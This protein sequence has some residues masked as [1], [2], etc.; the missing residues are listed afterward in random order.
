M[1]LCWR[2]ADD[3]ARAHVQALQR[4]SRTQ[5]ARKVP[6]SRPHAAGRAP[7]H[8]FFH[9]RGTLGGHGPSGAVASHL[10]PGSVPILMHLNLQEKKF[11]NKNKA[12]ATT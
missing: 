1:G 11:R 3:D 7:E 6:T 9:A 4:D 12:K 10:P 5:D 8:T 2:S